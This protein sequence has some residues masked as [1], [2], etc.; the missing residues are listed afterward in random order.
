MNYWFVGRTWS[1]KWIIYHRSKTLLFPNWK[2]IV[3]FQDYWKC[4]VLNWQIHGTIKVMARSCNSKMQKS[5]RVHCKSILITK[6]VCCFFENTSY[7]IRFTETLVNVRR[8]HADIVPTLAQVCD[9]SSMI[10]LRLIERISLGLYRIWK[11]R[12]NRSHRTKSYRIFLWSIFH[13][14]NRRSNI[15]LPS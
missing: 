11:T 14:S 2:F 7:Q 5:T 12:S 1:K 4:R 10:Q 15:S 3:S 8:R 6:G 9:F 13:E